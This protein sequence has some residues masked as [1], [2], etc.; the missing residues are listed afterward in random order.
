MGSAPLAGPQ[1]PRV[2]AKLWHL[3]TSAA[4]SLADPTMHQVLCVVLFKMLQMLLA[5]LQD[6]CF[7]KVN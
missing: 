2:S 6:P 5:K 3:V 4:F 7:G 1:P